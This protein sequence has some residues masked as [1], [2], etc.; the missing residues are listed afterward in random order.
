[1]FPQIEISH[2]IPWNLYSVF[3]VLGTESKT[4][5]QSYISS[6]FLFLFFVSR[7]V[8][9][10]SLSYPSW[11]QTCDPRVSAYWSKYVQSLYFCVSDQ[12]PSIACKATP[13]VTS[14]PPAGHFSRVPSLKSSLLGTSLGSLGPQGHNSM[15]SRMSSVSVMSCRVLETH[16]AV[17][18]LV[19]LGVIRLLPA[20]EFHL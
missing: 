10:V 12:R 9:T 18:L 3:S 15:A 14:L 2:R 8:L 5:T 16:S 7:Q 4:S 20:D 19:A 1:M 6:P 13:A 17:F 11:T